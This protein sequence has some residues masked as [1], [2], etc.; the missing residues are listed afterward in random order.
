MRLYHSVSSI[1]SH[2]Q[3]AR[4]LR[5]AAHNVISGPLDWVFADSRAILHC[6]R[7]D[8]AGLC[9][10]DNLVITAD[11]LRIQDRVFGVDFF[12]Q[13]P[14]DPEGRLQVH[15]LREARKA[16]IPRLDH[17]VANYRNI[18]GPHLFV[19]VIDEQHL[20]HPSAHD[21]AVEIHAALRHRKPECGL[22]VVQQGVP[23]EPLWADGILNR[24]TAATPGIW[25][26]DDEDWNEILTD[27]AL[28]RPEHESATA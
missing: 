26:G 9:E 27:L 3:A 1:G 8:F 14:R 13:F 7:Q 2:C 23:P 20:R 21:A 24:Y 25:Q 15:N 22:L 19:W 12:H 5:R 4:Q 10:W 6:I 18:Q 11:L 17:L 28:I 16:F